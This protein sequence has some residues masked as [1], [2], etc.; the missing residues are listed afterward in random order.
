VGL[1]FTLPSFARQAPP[2][3]ISISALCWLLLYGAS[4][5]FQP[6]ALLC[7]SSKSLPNEGIAFLTL[8]GVGATAISVTLLWTIMV[9]AMT[10]PLIARPI[11]QLQLRSLTQRRGRS[12]VLFAAAYLVV[13]I[14]VGPVML[15]AAMA[16]EALARTT[17]L[18]AIAVAAPIVAAWQATPLRQRALNRCHRLPNLSAF[19]TAADRDCIRFGLTHGL[20]CTATCAPLMLLP[21]TASTFHLA[22]MFII[23]VAVAFE[24]LAPARTPSWTLRILPGQS[25]AMML[26]RSMKSSMH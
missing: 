9:I 26:C 20:W 6:A 1:H 7:S 23:S 18:P 17:E 14:S 5:E 2:A 22:L 15:A 11:A 19:G 10:A 3:L 8:H 25:V 24:R 12:V 13:W 16:I 4:R 21:L